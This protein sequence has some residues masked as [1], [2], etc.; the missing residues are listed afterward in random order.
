MN[1]LALLDTIGPGPDL[2][3]IVWGVHLFFRTLWG[4]HLS[5][6]LRLLCRL[7]R[8][9]A[10]APALHGAERDVASVT[11]SHACRWLVK[12]KRKESY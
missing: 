1:E 5:P 2:A 8:I 11:R 9:N 4:V 12:E 3:A 7:V 10:H 6:G